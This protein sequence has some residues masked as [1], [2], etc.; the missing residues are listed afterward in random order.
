M[1]LHLVKYTFCG[2]NNLPLISAVTT[3]CAVSTSCLRFFTAW[4]KAE[5][6]M[7]AEM[8]LDF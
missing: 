7:E 6:K 1:S 2:K 4:V 8:H 5:K 3:V